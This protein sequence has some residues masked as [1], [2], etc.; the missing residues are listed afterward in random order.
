[1]GSI[2][3]AKAKSSA[4]LQDKEKFLTFQAMHLDRKDK[5]SFQTNM[6][7]VSFSHEL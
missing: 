3:E 2:P 1:M 6:F 4:S 7:S 5:Y